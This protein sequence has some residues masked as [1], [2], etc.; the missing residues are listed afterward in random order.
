[1]PDLTAHQERYL[2]VD[3]ALRQLRG[4]TAT[5]CL[6]GHVYEG[7]LPGYLVAIDRA[8][9]PEADRQALANLL[10]RLRA[11]FGMFECQAGQAACIDLQSSLSMPDPLPNAALMTLESVLIGMAA[12]L[13]AYSHRVE[14]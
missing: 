5:L 8:R 2:D 1:M 6:L 12:E 13:S 10:L 7:E 3:A 9:Q 4:D 14:V 11:T